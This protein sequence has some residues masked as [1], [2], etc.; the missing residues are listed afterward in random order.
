MI[1]VLFRGCA[2]KWNLPWRVDTSVNCETQGYRGSVWWFCNGDLCNDADMTSEC[3]D[4]STQPRHSNTP[5]IQPAPSKKYNSGYGKMKKAGYGIKTVPSAETVHG[6]AFINPRKFLTKYF[7]QRKLPIQSHPQLQSRP[8]P[9]QTKSYNPQ[10]KSYIPQPKSYIPQPKRYI[11]QQKIDAPKSYPQTKSQPPSKSYPH[12]IINYYAEPKNDAPKSYQQ[13]K[14]QPQPKGYPHTIVNYYPEPNHDLPKS[15]QHTKSQPQPSY[16]KPSVY[17]SRRT[18]QKIPQATSP[19]ITT[20]PPRPTTTTPAKTVQPHFKHHYT[21]KSPLVSMPHTGNNFFW[22]FPWN[23]DHKG[24]DS[25]P[26]STYYTGQTDY[27]YA[28]VPQPQLRPEP[29]PLPLPQPQPQPQTFKSDY[30]DYKYPSKIY[31]PEPQKSVD[32]SAYSYGNDALYPNFYIPDTYQPLL[33]RYDQ[34]SVDIGRNGDYGLKATNIPQIGAYDIHFQQ[35]LAPPS[36]S[37]DYQYQQ[38][39]VKQDF[40]S[41]NIQYPSAPPPTIQYVPTTEERNAEGHVIAHDDNTD[42]SYYDEYDSRQRDN[43]VYQS[44]PGNYTHFLLCR[45]WISCDQNSFPN[46]SKVYCH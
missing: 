19:I 35:P 32:F 45:L 13:P 43:N 8:P 46:M 3:G 10:P 30:Y 37:V 42:Y 5:P 23:G 26:T 22:L 24:Y 29:L 34:Q 36:K 20:P 41:I 16:K 38:P 28:P 9:A 21:W 18:G 40:T 44:T 33:E 4:I 27:Q 12:P 14:S 15:Y 11:P 6:Q 17:F 1:V 25:T 2:D 39:Q 7:K 31:N